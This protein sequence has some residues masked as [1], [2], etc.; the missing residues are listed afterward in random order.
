MAYS[1]EMYRYST[2][3]YCERCKTQDYTIRVVCIEVTGG[4]AAYFCTN[5]IKDILMYLEHK[6]LAVHRSFALYKDD[7]ILILDPAGRSTSPSK[8]QLRGSLSQCEQDISDMLKRFLQLTDGYTDRTK[9]F[10]D[11][12][13]QLKRVFNYVESYLNKT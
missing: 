9:F 13:K 5:C 3:C 7:F 2:G 11:I 1:R 6:V 12:K 4:G 10:F 8:E